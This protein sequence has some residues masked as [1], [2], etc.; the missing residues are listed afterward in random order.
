MISVVPVF[1]VYQKSINMV[2]IITA[3][4]E[5]P[6]FDRIVALTGQNREMLVQ[7]TN[8]STSLVATIS[9]YSWSVSRSPD[10]VDYKNE[11][12]I[13]DETVIV[14]RDVTERPDAVQGGTVALIGADAEWI[15]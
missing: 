15:Y 7:A 14:M 4:P 6:G 12:T 13:P 1:G 9:C 10:P 5:P 11:A 2:P 3:L 8:T